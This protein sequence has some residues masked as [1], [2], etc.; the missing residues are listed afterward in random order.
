M[1][2]SPRYDGVADWYEHHFGDARLLIDFEEML[3]RLLGTG[4]GDLLDVGCGTGRFAQALTKLGWTV[5]GIDV[6]EDMLRIARERG[7]DVVCADATALPFADTSFDAVISMWTH[8]DVDDFEAAV[9][10][11]ARVLVPGEPF[12]YMGAHPCFV[13]PHS[14]FVAT[15]GVPTLH[16]G[17][18]EAARYIDAPGVTP[19]GLRAKVGATHLPLGRLLQTF[20]DAGFRIEHFEESQ[21]REYPY[22][23]ALR[24]RT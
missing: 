8:T 4:D 7:L 9:R 16:P 13:G 19:D 14:A 2:R 17:Y 18:R 3:A 15:Q 20:C 22:M 1:T 5:T 12:V 6:S 21:E 23:V 24:C 11:V 10:E